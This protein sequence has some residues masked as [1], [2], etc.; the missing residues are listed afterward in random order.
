LG[1]MSTGVLRYGVVSMRNPREA[2]REFNLIVM[3]PLR[4]PIFV[5]RNSCRP[6][7]YRRPGYLSKR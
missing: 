4:Y 6:A 1:L 5:L 7:A 3:H 2:D